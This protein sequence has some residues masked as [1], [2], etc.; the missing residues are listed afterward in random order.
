MR[1]FTT[2]IQIAFAVSLLLG[3]TSKQKPEIDGHPLEGSITVKLENMG[4]FASGSSW[5]LDVNAD[6]TAYLNILAYPTDIHRTFAVPEEEMEGLRRLLIEQRFFELDDEY[7]EIVLDASTRTLA[8]TCGDHSHSVELHFL[9]NWVHGD[10]RRLR[11]PARV[12]RVW[13]YVR[14][15]FS[16]KEAV[17]LKRYDD[18]VLDATPS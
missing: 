13:R 15:W 16:D 2:Q 9:M 8:V 4:G 18:M 1:Y 3:C 17:D 14:T 11:D 5:S 10:T 12:V 6:G 7:G